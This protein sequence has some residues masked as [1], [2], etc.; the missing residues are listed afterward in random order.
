[1]ATRK[2]SDAE[3]WAAIENLQAEE[4]MAEILAM[5]PAEVDADLRKAGMD[6]DQ[7]R[8]E[9]LALVAKLRER[10]VRLGWQASATA[11]LEKVR[12]MAK[13]GEGRFAGLS[14]NEL[15]DRI[16]AAENDPR[17][18]GQVGAM[19]RKRSVEESSAEE[20]AALLEELDLLAKLNDEGDGGEGGA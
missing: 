18:S 5:S 2:R 20:L 13:A 9:G 6:P 16:R 12:A 19:F 17:F 7:V 14:K 3:T 15:R 8:A 4:D 11:K 1:M 10:H